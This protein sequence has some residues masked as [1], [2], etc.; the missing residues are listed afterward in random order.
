MRRR[1]REPTG[2]RFAVAMPQECPHVCQPSEFHAD[3]AGENVV[4]EKRARGVSAL[5]GDI[6][7]RQALTP[8]Y[9]PR[10]RSALEE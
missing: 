9:N 8:S 2:W 5:A 3:E 4:S 7:A 1:R 6:N 10:I